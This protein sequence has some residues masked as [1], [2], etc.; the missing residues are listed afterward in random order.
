MESKVSGDLSSI[1]SKA[2]RAEGSPWKLVCGGLDIFTCGDQGVTVSAVC[3]GM[4]GHRRRDTD[5]IL[6]LSKSTIEDFSF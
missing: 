1:S 2:A 5:V 3:F 6:R 4:N